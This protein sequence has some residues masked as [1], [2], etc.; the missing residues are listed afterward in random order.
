MLTPYYYPILGGSETQIENLSL[1]L[2]EVGVSTDIMTFNFDE[3]GKPLPFRKIEKVNGLNVIRIPAFNPLPSKFHHNKINFM[4]NFIPRN[5]AHILHEYD[6]LHFQNETDLSFPVLS[7][8]VNKP[9]VF[10]LRCLNVTY[11]IFKRNFV[12]RHLLR[13]IADVHIAQSKYVSQLLR[14][15]GI[16]N[17]KIKVIHNAVNTSMFKPGSRERAENRLLYVGRIEQYKGL[18]VL[19]RSLKHIHNPVQLLVIGPLVGEINYHKIVIK[20]ITEINEK[21]NHKVTYLGPKKP[22]EILEYYQTAS[23]VVVPSLS[24]SFGNVILETLACETPVI[25]SNVGGIPEIISNYENGILV[26]PGNDVKLAEAI[27]FLLS[28][29][30]MKEKLGRQGR[31]HVLENF[32]FEVTAKKLLEIYN[33]LLMT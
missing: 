9:K 26:P 5:F 8:T 32:S 1:K 29:Q 22:H 16:P 11:S 12:C 28:N 23:I 18:H 7:Y 15:L 19:L 21:T 27:Q 33:K 17:S 3:A 14:N 20:L 31:L 2:N 25:A 10:H 13:N 24:E 4:I 30:D 6:I